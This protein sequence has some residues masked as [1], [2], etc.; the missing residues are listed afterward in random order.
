VVKVA[1]RGLLAHKGRLFMTFLAVA[2][3]VSFVAGV[4]VLTDTMNRAFDDLFAD[5]YRDTDAVVRSD[6]TIGSDF[7][8]LRGTIDDSL[9]ADVEDAPGVTGADGVVAGFARVIDRDGDPVGNPTMGAPT[10]GG[11]WTEV[12]NPFD[13][14]DGRPPEDDGE[15]VL[16]RGTAR[17]TE[18]GVGDTV[19]VQTQT[20]AGEYEVVGVARFGTADNPGGSSYVLWTTEEA[21]RLIG[22]PGRFSSVAAVAE[23]GVSQE[24]LAASID[25]TLR[26]AGATDVEVLTGAQITE[27][28]QSDIKDQLSFF[29]IFLLVFAIIAVVVGAFVIYNSFSIII[30]QRTREM[31]L[32][33]AIGARR[34]QVRRA[35]V[36]EAIIVGLVG[37]AIGFLVG[38]AIAAFLGDLFDLPPGSLAIV[39]TSVF[40]AVLTG[41]VVTVFSALLPAWRA[42]RVPPLAAMRDVDV[43][44]SGRSRVRLAIGVVG[45]ALGA[46]IVVAGAL[47]D[48][49][50]IVGLGVALVFVALLFISPGVARP[51]SRAL[52]APLARLRGVTGTLARENAARNPRRT[53]ATAQALMIGVGLIAFIL[54]IDASIRASIDEALEESFTGDFVVDS[55]TFGMVGLPPHL[56]NDIRDLRDVAIVAPVRFSPA[57]VTVDPDGPDAIS[58]ETLVGGAN[59]GAFE[60]LDLRTVEGTAEL[61]PGEVVITEDKA[62]SEG[63]SL[64]D[65]IEVSF[66]DDRRPE[67]DRVATVA[68]IYDDSTAAGGLGAVVLGLDDWDAAVPVPT[69]NQVFVQLAEGVSVAEAEPEIE[70]VVEPFATAEV[71]SV[72]EY[73]DA[74]GGQLDLLLR[75]VFG[76]L[77]FA[78][79]IAIIGIANTIALSVLE[80]TRE[81]GLLRAVGMRRRQI[82]SAIR[83]EAVII[84][85]F[86]SVLGLGFGLLGG[87][88]IVRAL[89][90]EG[91]GV[92]QVPIGWL[93]VVAAI[94]GL[95]GLIAALL[96]AWRASRMN[97]L[98]AISTE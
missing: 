73:K 67:A 80:R 1:L 9:L 27:E 53:S 18:F 21:Q 91:F 31:A 63:L 7:G 57:T 82:R 62:R 32:L 89:R 24:E 65:P 5:V 38:L 46:A 85:L 56:A 81:L 95:L 19:Q 60:L 83:W 45:L 64:G 41:L 12:L 49:I 6:Q 70:R 79:I 47:G 86:G 93:A 28:T 2:L 8:D 36:V 52:G 22:E 68:G 48:D 51:V 25:D 78:V 40:T 98:D 3:G 4:L 26:S 87:W 88:G 20:E 54:V 44:T 30:A 15:I 74:I 94:A 77:A 43:D 84:A 76:L 35:V 14:T 23:S 71:Q 90:D 72:D 37:S 92:F 33:R 50:A 75:L 58:D 61:G 97:V 29:T 59:A 13:I 66:L 10:L 11:N 42:A 17:D 34:R 39:P 69:D 96:P 16:D 55:G